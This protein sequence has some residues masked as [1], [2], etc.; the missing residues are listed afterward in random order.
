M[1]RTRSTD[2]RVNGDTLILRESAAFNIW[3][4]GRKGALVAWLDAPKDE[5][6]TFEVD[7]RLVKRGDKLIAFI[8]VYNG[9][10]SFDLRASNLGEM[11]SALRTLETRI[12]GLEK[13]HSCGTGF[14]LSASRASSSAL[15]IGVSIAVIGSKSA[16]G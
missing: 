16:V 5:T 14:E 1:L 11:A 8:K 6:Y 2:V 12:Q 13:I 4:S 7:C 3:T 10:F 15:S 9:E